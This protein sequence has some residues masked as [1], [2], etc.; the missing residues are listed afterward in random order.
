MAGEVYGQWKDLGL[1]NH[2]GNLPIISLLPGGHERFVKNL[3]TGELRK[4]YVYDNQS[5]GDAI[6]KGQWVKK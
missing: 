1:S 5:V 3:E 2:P 6:A 4:L